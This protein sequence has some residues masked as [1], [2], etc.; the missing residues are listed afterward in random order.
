MLGKGRKETDWQRF[1][2]K[3]Q[4][5]TNVRFWHKTDVVQANV[6]YE[7]KAE[8]GSFSLFDRVVMQSRIDQ[9]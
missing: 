8:I 2:S 6:R 1:R 9:K 5:L 3:V 4:S 7:R